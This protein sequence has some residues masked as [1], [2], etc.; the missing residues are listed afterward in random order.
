[1]EHRNSTVLA[2]TGS[3]ASNATGLLGTLSHEFFHS[4]N[5]ERIR[6]TS[7][8]PFDFT[9]ENMSGALWFAEGFTSYYDD[10]LIRRAGLT[11]DAGYATGLA[12]TINAVVNGPGREYFTAVEMSM[13]APFVDAAVSNDPTNR[14]NTFISYY[15]WG[16]AIGLGLDLTLRSRFDVTLDDYMRAMWRKY[17][18]TEHPYTIDSLRI[19]LGEVT[20]DTGFADDFFARYIQGHEVVDYA[21]LLE[22]AGILVRRARPDQATLG[23]AFFQVRDGRLIVASGTIVGS[24]LYE[25]GIDRGDQIVS[26]DG[27]SVSAEAQV[28]QIVARHEP[29][30]TVAVEFFSRG[31]THTAR[32]TLVEDPGLEVATF[33]TAGRE[34][35]PAMAAFRSAWLGSKATQ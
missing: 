13:Q 2:S 27:E 32:I 30:D 1:M 18:K 16:A 5:V 9:R 23:P 20:N 21:A 6:P 10:L 12:G 7:L 8:E 33:E 15:T 25:A 19:T 11:E 3:L 31:A 24:P 17:G 4:W 34:L 14:V 35:T 29:G 28:E 26:L 22:H